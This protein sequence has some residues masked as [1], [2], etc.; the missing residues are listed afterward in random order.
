MSV[1]ITHPDR[2]ELSIYLYAPDG[3][4]YVLKRN[5][6]SGANL[7]ETYTVDLD[8]EDGDGTWTLS[9]KDYASGNTGTIDSWSLDLA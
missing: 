2:G 5:G 7:S 6:D 9:V 3:S 4:Y 8:T 1:E